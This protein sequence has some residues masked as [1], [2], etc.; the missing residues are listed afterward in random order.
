MR[1]ILTVLVSVLLALFSVDFANAGGGFFGGRG[2]C[3][4]SSYGSGCGGSSAYSGGCGGGSSS[5]YGGSGCGDSGYG[6]G[7]GNASSYGGCGAGGC[8]DGAKS[9][10]TYNWQYFRCTGC[11]GVYGEYTENSKRYRTL[12]NCKAIAKHEQKSPCKA[13]CSKYEDEI[14]SLQ[15]QVALLQE[16]GGRQVPPLPPLD[17]GPKKAEQPQPIEKSAD[18]QPKKEA[19]PEVPQLQDFLQR[20]SSAGNLHYG[21]QVTRI[22]LGQIDWQHTYVKIAK[23]QNGRTYPYVVINGLVPIVKY[24]D[25]GELLYYDYGPARAVAEAEKDRK[26]L[27]ADLVQVKAR[28]ATLR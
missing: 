22:N 16:Q 4:A 3:G 15:E 6:G 26:E 9:T 21:K 10:G 1:P 8:G 20:Q 14:K 12:C 25:K 27:Q 7:C 18:P 28:L 19:P 2:G 5:F 17:L 13:D 11:N 23:S 24:G